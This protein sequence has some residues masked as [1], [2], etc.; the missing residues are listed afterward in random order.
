MTSLSRQSCQKRCHHIISRKSQESVVD[1][2][3]D[4][5]DIKR[6]VHHIKR[7][8]HHIKR[9]V[10]HIKRDVH[11]IKRNV[12]K[13]ACLVIPRALPL[14]GAPRIAEL[15]ECV[16]V[17]RSNRLI[18]CVRMSRIESIPDGGFIAAARASTLKQKSMRSI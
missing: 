14:M 8:V 16:S 18:N 15:D 7:D 17:C 1:V 9:D 3:R 5:H 2:K 11:D 4:V 13:L 10:H 6:D 12:Q